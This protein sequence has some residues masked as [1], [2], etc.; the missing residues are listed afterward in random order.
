MHLL[1]KC[2]LRFRYYTIEIA[3]ESVYVINK[4]VPRRATF[5]KNLF[6]PLLLKYKFPLV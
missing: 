1:I 4:I 3:D 2:I 6:T 5:L